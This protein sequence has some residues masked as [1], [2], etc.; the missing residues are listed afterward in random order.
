MA[1]ATTYTLRLTPPPPRP[2]HLAP[3]LPQ[4][5]RRAAAKVAASW[6]PAGGGNSDDGVGG[7]WLPEQP[8][9]K[10]RAGRSL[11]GFVAHRVLGCGE[12]APLRGYFVVLL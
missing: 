3:L 1:T 12:I 6:A 11:N 4:L 7:W 9:E 2:R 10:G 8:A 5:R